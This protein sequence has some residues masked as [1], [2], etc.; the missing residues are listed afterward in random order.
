MPISDPRNEYYPNQ[1]PEATGELDTSLGPVG[2]PLSVGG[3]PRGP[4]Q[5]DARRMAPRVAPIAPPAQQAYAQPAQSVPP[6]APASRRHESSPPSG[7]DSRA[8]RREEP[9]VDHLQRAIQGFKS[10]LPLVQKLMPLLDGPLAH[11]VSSLLRPQQPVAESAKPTTL[12]P[13]AVAPAPPSV[14]LQGAT[15]TAMA[16]STVEQVI[17]V[18]LTPIEDGLRRLQSGNRELQT[19]VSEQNTALRRVEDQLEMVREAT[20]RNT[21]EQQELM[22]D[23]KGIGKRVNAITLILMALLLGSLLLNLILYLH[24]QRVLP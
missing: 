18:D 14:A 9:I 12:A 22:D 17:S 4:Q 19:Q 5:P 10:A 15:P 20:D 6:V 2:S 16:T 11:T 8:D 21:L 7:E 23:L 3:R 1:N 13:S 24:M